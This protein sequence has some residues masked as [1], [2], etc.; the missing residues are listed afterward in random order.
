MWLHES[1]RTDG[2]D[3]GAQKSMWVCL[4]N[5]GSFHGQ[6]AFDA[7]NDVQTVDLGYS[8]PY[9]PIGHESWYVQSCKIPCKKKHIGSIIGISIV[10]YHSITPC[11]NESKIVFL[12]TQLKII[13]VLNSPTKASPVQD[14]GTL[15]HCHLSGLGSCE[16]HYLAT[17]PEYSMTKLISQIPKPLIQ[18][19][20]ML[21][22]HPPPL[23]WLW[24]MLY[25][26]LPH[27]NC[28]FVAYIWDWPR[29]SSRNVVLIENVI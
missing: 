15:E 1:R 29:S 5:K 18:L 26:H 12:M 11:N 4:Q 7:E 24:I 27:S 17:C 20:K 8:I 13:K 9:T 23:E 3:P 2:K 25:H 21:F 14:V 19:W 16:S 10:A 6:W 28:H 22:N